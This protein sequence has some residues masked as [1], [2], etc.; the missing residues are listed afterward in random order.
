M[1]IIEVKYIKD[2]ILECHFEDGKV[3]TANFQ[4]FLMNAQNP[5]T[6]QFRDK[7]RFAQVQI[8]AVGSLTWEDG[9]MDIPY[10]SI[11]DGEF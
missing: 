5:M 10:W 2:Y 6:T 8:T 7:E 11:Y 4:K 9:Q 1:R 3:V